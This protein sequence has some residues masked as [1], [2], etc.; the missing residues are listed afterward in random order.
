MASQLSFL[1]TYDKDSDSLLDYIVTGDEIWVKYLNCETKK[2]IYGT[3]PYS[4][5]QKFDEPFSE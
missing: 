1:E 5:I 3:G 2:I 4:L